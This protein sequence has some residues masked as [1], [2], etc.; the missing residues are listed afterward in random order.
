M[1]VTFN[2]LL[3]EIK[4]VEESKTGSKLQRV[5]LKIPARVNQFGETS[6]FDELHEVLIFK[7]EKINEFWEGY[8]DKNPTKKIKITCYINSNTRIHE[9]KTF[10]NTQLSYKSKVWIY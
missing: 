7:A 10:Y 3:E 9:G 5:I 4:P 2:A 1:E 6:G 8:S